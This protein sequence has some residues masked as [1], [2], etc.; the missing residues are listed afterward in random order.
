MDAWLKTHIA[1]VSPIA[2]AIYM[3]GGDNRQLARDRAGVA[4]MLRAIREGFQAVRAAG[5]PITPF[6]LRFFSWT[7]ETLLVPCL[8]R[9]LNTTWA[10]LVMARHANA[11]RDEMKQLADEFRMLAQVAS[12]PTPAI[13]RLYAYLN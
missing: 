12:V 3:A 7:P 8:Q 13:D 5:I 1:L 10:E 9:V 6:R 2:N 11:A 4:L